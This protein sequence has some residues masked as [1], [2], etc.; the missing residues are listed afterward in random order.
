MNNY[1]QNGYRINGAGRRTPREGSTSYNGPYGEV[2]PE[3][4]I[5]FTLQVCE[6]VGISRVEV[7][8]GVGKSVIK[9]FKR[10]FH[11]FPMEG[12]RKGCLFCQKI[13]YKRV[14][15]RTSG[16]RLP[17]LNFFYYPLGVSHPIFLFLRRLLLKTSIAGIEARGYCTKLDY[18][19][20][21]DT[22]GNKLDGLGLFS[23]LSSHKHFSV[24]NSARPGLGDVSEIGHLVS[25][26]SHQS[27]TCILCN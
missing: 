3:R 18:A 26:L 11:Y 10:A 7:I 17:V 20:N 5:F 6:R 1:L 15:G 14:R 13:V 4:G 23:L 24:R 19:K 9:V 16:R 21:S 12:L 8:E 25:L 22:R 2:P 27:I